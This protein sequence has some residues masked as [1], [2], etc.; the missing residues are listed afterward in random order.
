MSTQ[1]EQIAKRQIAVKILD[2]L[3]KERFSQWYQKE[4]ESYISGDPEAKLKDEIL[5]DIVKL[6]RLE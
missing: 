3:E 5:E 1:T 2:A 4:F 6:F